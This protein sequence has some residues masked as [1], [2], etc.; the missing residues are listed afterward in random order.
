MPP[1]HGPQLTDTTRQPGLKK[2]FAS[3][4]V[5][6]I[7][8]E[9]GASYLADELRASSDA[10]EVV[11]LAGGAPL[12]AEPVA[13]S[14]PA[15]PPAL[16]TAFER[17]LDLASYPVLRSHVFDGRPVLPMALILE[18]LAHAGLHQNPGLVFHGCDDLRVLQGVTLDGPAV[19]VRVGA[20]KAVKRDGLLVA[21]AELRSTRPDGREVLHARAE[22]VLA[23]DLP[24]APAA[25][26]VGPL[27]PAGLTPQEVYREGLLFHGPDLQG[28]ERLEG[29]DEG[30]IAGVVRAAPPPAEWLRQPLRQRWLADPLVLDGAFQLMILWALERRGAAGLPCH[31]RRYRQ[32]RRNFPAG[33]ARLA[34]AV[35]RATDLH[36]LADLDFLDEDGRLVARMEGYECVIDPNLGRAF[37]R[38]QL[39]PA[40]P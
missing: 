26:E 5:G 37:R 34:A 27:P 29:C 24:A 19:A 11:L 33:G 39:A 31:V 3:E 17:V 7:Q 4:G 12:P 1:S 36:A 15:L 6:L 13:P 32:W 2:L 23:A 22:V 28:L 14:A 8:P 20:G 21:P 25:R 18:W 30:G 10:V 38:N 35:T 9:A 16:P 40:L